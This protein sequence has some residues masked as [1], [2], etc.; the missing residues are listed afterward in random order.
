MCFPGVPIFK[1]LNDYNHHFS[2]SPALKVTYKEVSTHPSQKYLASKWF[3]RGV[4][5]FLATEKWASLELSEKA[6]HTLRG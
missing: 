1:I 4:L 6:T 2:D 5:G 3:K